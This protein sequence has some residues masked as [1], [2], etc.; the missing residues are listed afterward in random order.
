MAVQ[1]RCKICD[2]V[3]ILEFIVGDA[4]WKYMTPSKRGT[5]CLACLDDCACKNKIAY[6]HELHRLLYF[7]GAQA[8]IELAIQHILTTRS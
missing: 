4:I 6:A 2:R 7:N 5:V 8:T 3:M 1:K